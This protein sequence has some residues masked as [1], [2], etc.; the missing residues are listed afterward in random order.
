MNI[1]AINTAFNNSYVALGVNEKS[2]VKTVD[3]SLKQSEN[4][5]GIISDVLNDAN[6][7]VSDLNALA[8]VIGPGSFTGIRIGVGICKGFCAAFKNIKKIDINSLDLLAYTHSEKANNDFYVVLNALSGNLFVCKYSKDGKR[9]CEP[10]L[11]S[12]NTNFDHEVVGLKSEDLGMCNVFYELSSNTLL[13]Y[14]LKKYNQQIFVDNFLPLYLRK[15]QA[16]AELD[17]KSN[18][19]T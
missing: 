19:Q 15:S 2:Y 3:S 16:E 12:D 7:K 4:I 1:L 9:L 18:N 14:A 10:Y 6:L 11:L 8:C 13:E 5:L 17:K